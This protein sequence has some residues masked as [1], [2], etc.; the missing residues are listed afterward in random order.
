MFKGLGVALVTPFKGAKVDYDV[1]K[2]LLY[3]HVKNG[4]DFLVILGST[5]EAQTLSL[6][7]KKD[8]IKFSVD[9][10]GNQIPIMVGTGTNDTKESI[11]LSRLAES[12]GAKGLLVVTP[13]YNKPPQRGLIKHFETIAKSTNL[14]VMLYNVPSRTGINLFVES[15]KKLSKNP[16]IIGIKEASGD[17]EQ[18]KKIIDQT[19]KDFIVLTGNDDQLYETLKLGGDGAISVTGNLVPKELKHLIMNHKHLNETDFI[20]YND[21]HQSMFIET[22]PIP[23]KAALIHMGFEVGSPRLP[24]VKI[25]KKHDKLLIEAL[26]KYKLVK[27]D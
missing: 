18:V 2:D 25:D 22:N 14:P 8:I 13:Y 21:L 6:K 23:V 16:K 24:L 17:L 15:V 27:H 19:H 3:F 9:T 4:T 1:L 5:G 12:Y 7:E 26:K 10:V 11:K 20:K